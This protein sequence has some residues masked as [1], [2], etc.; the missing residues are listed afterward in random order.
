MNDLLMLSDFKLVTCQ[1]EYHECFGKSIMV[2]DK[3]INGHKVHLEW[4]VNHD[5]YN[6]K[7]DAKLFRF[8]MTREEARVYVEMS[9]R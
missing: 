4:V 3:E 9:I 6:V 2:A 7:V 1:D 5:W 8:K